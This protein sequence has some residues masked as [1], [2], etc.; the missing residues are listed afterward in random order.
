MKINKDFEI[1]QH[2][3]DAGKIYTNL[4]D[5]KLRVYDAYS[6][7]YSTVLRIIK[8]CRKKTWSKS[9]KNNYL[10]KLLPSLNDTFEPADIDRRLF[11][12]EDAS[13]TAKTT[14][15]DVLSDKYIKNLIDEAIT[16]TTQ[17]LAEFAYKPSVRFLN[18]MLNT[19]ISRADFCKNYFGVQG[20][21]FA[22]EI[23]EKVKSP[24]F[25]VINK[26]FDEIKKVVNKQINKRFELYYGE[27]GTGKT[28]QALGLAKKCVVCASD[29]LPNDIMENFAFGE[30]GNAKFEKSDFWIAMENGEPIILDEINCLPLETLRFL[31]GILDNKSAID[32]KG[33]HI[34][35]KDGFK[36]IGTMN[37][38]VSGMVASIPA[39]LADRAADIIEFDS[40]VAFLR[41]AFV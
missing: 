37:L 28:T 8:V 19:S 35:I 33:H 24:E 1:T 15:T 4:E 30:K 38:V 27:P 11:E 12:L 17:F 41:N 5:G 22:L 16:K 7:K 18:S 31:Q 9:T 25:R 32:Y 23:A 21:S 2:R 20:H 10:K 39:P 40:S 6:D 13:A 3:N 14:S 34:E 29:M 36:V 26:L